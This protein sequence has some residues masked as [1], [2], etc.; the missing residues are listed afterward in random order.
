M[1]G[2]TP[3]TSTVRGVYANQV[4]KELDSD[5]PTLH[6]GFCLI[7]VVPQFI[8]ISPGLFTEAFRLCYIILA[9]PCPPKQSM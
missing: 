8:L 6:K 1:K 9:V 7:L 4:K 3:P 2:A 5:T